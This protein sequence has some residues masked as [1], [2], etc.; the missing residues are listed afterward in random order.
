MRPSFRY[1][2]CCANQLITSLALNKLK[3]G[4]SLK[5]TCTKDPR[6]KVFQKCVE[7]GNFRIQKLALLPKPGGSNIQI[8]LQHAKAASAVM[9]KRFVV[10]PLDIQEP[11]YDKDKRKE[12]LMYAN[13]ERPRACLL[14][15]KDIKLVPLKK[16]V[17]EMS[18]QFF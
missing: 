7:E 17:V 5:A 2:L 6:Q 11:H 18:Q 10:E 8:N 4:R 13:K 9:T 16:I 3:V 12:S 14:M 1:Q 15:N